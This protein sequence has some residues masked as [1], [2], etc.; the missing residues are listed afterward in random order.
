MNYKNRTDAKE[1]LSVGKIIVLEGRIAHIKD[2]K[3][4]LILRITDDFLKCIDGLVQLINDG[5][6]DIRDATIEEKEYWFLC[7]DNCFSDFGSCT[8]TSCREW[9]SGLEIN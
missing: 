9:F 3:D 6:G 2:S 5:Y 4:D 7:H 1:L 8:V